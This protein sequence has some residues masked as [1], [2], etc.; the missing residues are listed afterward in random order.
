MATFRP[1]LGGTMLTQLSKRR[2]AQ[3]QDLV[4]LLGECHQKIRHFVDLARDIA[5]H[6]DVPAEQVAQ[7]C[8]DVERYFREALPLHVADEEE[9]IEP[10]LRGQSPSVDHVLDTM[11]AQHQQH[12]SKVANLLGAIAKVRSQ[13]CD[14]VARSELAAAAIALRTEFVDHLNLEETTIFPAIRE[15]LPSDTQA[16]IIEELRQRRRFDRRTWA[17]IAQENQS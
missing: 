5:L 1:C 9:S 10:R 7:A 11:A 12:A 17:A 14:D 15:L 16:L 13:P 3:C 6:R 8:A 2:E 4:A